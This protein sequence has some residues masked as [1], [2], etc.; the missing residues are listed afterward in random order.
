MVLFIK[1]L[2]GEEQNNTTNKTK[3]CDNRG[4][5]IPDEERLGWPGMHVLSEV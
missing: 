3:S 1:H 5:C 2:A 4:L